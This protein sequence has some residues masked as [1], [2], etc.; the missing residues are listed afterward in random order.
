MNF[1]FEDASDP[2]RTRDSA[3]FASQSASYGREGIE[4]L[5]C[6]YDDNAVVDIDA[7][8]ET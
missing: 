7:D 8:K 6:V 4:R 5:L 1:R 2:D 3:D